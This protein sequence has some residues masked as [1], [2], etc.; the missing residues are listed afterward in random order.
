M[1]KTPQPTAFPLNGLQILKLTQASFLVRL[2]APIQ[3][4]SKL[5]PMGKGF[6][7]LMSQSRAGTTEVSSCHEGRPWKG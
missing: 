6:Q 1:C 3:S 4:S 5:A 7:W 2:P